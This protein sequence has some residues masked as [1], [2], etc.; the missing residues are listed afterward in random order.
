MANIKCTGD[1]FA[2]EAF[3]NGETDEF[4]PS[5]IV[6]ARTIRMMQKLESIE[7]LNQK[8]DAILEMLTEKREKKQKTVKV[9]DINS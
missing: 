5:K 8:V 3:L 7:I 2:C 4:C 1:C 6:Q 9:E